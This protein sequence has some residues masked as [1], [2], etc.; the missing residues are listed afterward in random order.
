VDLVYSVFATINFFNIMNRWGGEGHTVYQK[1]LENFQR[2]FSQL[3]TCVC[4]HILKSAHL[5]KQLSEDYRRQVC[6][7]V[8]LKECQDLSFWYFGSQEE[9]KNG[10]KTL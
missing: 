7:Y 2:L 6:H 8:P 5:Q 3:Q 4:K 1:E 10:K 9:K